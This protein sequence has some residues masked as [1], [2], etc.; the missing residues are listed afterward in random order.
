MYAGVDIK[1]LQGYGILNYNS[2]S[3]TNVDGYQAL[4]P[5]YD[6][7]YDEPT[8]SQIEGQGLKTAGLG[9]GFDFGLSFEIYKQARIAMAINDIGSILWDGNVYEGENVPVYSIETPGI[10][11]Y[12]IF[13][14]SGG[15]VV[16][17]DYL[18]EWKGVMERRIKLP[19]HTRL[20][21]NY[22]A[23]DK[24]TVG[25]EV[26]IPLEKEVPGA[27]L[28]EYYAAG[29]QYVPSSWFQLSGGFTYGGGFG[30]KIP[31]GVTFRPMNTEKTLWEVGFASRDMITWFKNDDPMVSFVFGF[32][33]FGFGG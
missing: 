1:L 16:D 23:I 6:I 27:L 19:M 30:F 5:F 8:P 18:G 24:L 21:A 12:D 33:R 22:Q 7:E 4:S 28:N 9:Y 20:G 31:M 3:Y 32:L 10:D 11:S 13:T 25:L 2:V 15:I 29:V 26:L 14:E 17:N